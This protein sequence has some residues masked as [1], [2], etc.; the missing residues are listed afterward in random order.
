MITA[1][2]IVRD[3]TKQDEGPAKD[4][5]GVI[6]EEIKIAKRCSFASGDGGFLSTRHCKN[7]E[8]SGLFVWLLLLSERTRRRRRKE[9]ARRSES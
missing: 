2:K 3:Q 6:D 8:K 4:L 5:N 9:R 1:V 7:Q